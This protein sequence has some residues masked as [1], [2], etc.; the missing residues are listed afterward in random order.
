MAASHKSSTRLIALAD[1]VI[2]LLV[3]VSVKQALLPFTR[4]YAGPA[5]TF[6]AMIVATLLLHYRG[7]TW[8]NLGLKWPQ[9]WV[10]TVGLTFVTLAAFFA[11]LAV[12][13]TLADRLFIDVGATGRFDHVEGNLT[14]YVMIM[15]LVWTHGSFFEELLFRAFIISKT[16][17]FLGNGVRAQLIAVLASAIFFGY[18]HYYYQGLHG[19]LITGGIG[20]IFGCLYIWFGRRNILPLILAHGAINSLAQTLRFLGMGD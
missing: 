8:A 3:L 16:S 17:E 19:A 15:L 1:L 18:R 14:A 7:F 5:S 9:S 6:S 20:L 12:F 13:Q 11:G 4:L 10:K 2:I